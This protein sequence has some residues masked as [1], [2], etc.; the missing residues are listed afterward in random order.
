MV[1]RITFI[2][3]YNDGN[4]MRRQ[5]TMLKITK[6]ISI[7]LLYCIDFTTNIPIEFYHARVC[8]EQC[9]QK[10]FL[11][12]SFKHVKNV[13]NLL[14]GHKSENINFARDRGLNC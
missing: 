6:I 9:M 14:V 1:L 13:I 5:F 2:S 8:T 12:R 7:F 10:S 11:I 4:L 3:N